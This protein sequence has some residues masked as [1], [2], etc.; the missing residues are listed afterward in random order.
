MITLPAAKAKEPLAAAKA[1]EKYK[2]D[3][4][5]KFMANCANEN[6]GDPRLHRE[7]VPIVFETYGAAGPTTLEHMSL[8]RHQYGNVVLP[9]EDKSSESIFHSTWAHQL[10]TALQLGNAEAIYNI[11][12]G[13]RTQARPL[14]DIETDLPLQHGQGDTAAP[15]RSIS[16]SN[17]GPGTDGEGLESEGEG[18]TEPD[19]NA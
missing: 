9:C 16:G 11:P 15:T 2:R 14:G 7:V 1:G 10:S 6:P 13:T 18:D 19:P 17:T 4:Y 3:K 8:V 5:S 12:R